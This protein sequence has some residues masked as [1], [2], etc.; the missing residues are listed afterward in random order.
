MWADADTWAKHE[1]EHVA[2]GHR[3]RSKRLLGVA[4]ALARAPSASLPRAMGDWAGAKAAYRLMAH[5]AVT[6]AA[7]LGAH[8]ARTAERAQAHARV[9]V[10]HD[11]TSVDFTGRGARDGLGPIHEAYSRGL[12]VHTSLAIL[13]D[14]TPLGVL[15]Q[16][17]WARPLHREGPPSR[18]QAR[19]VRRK[20]EGRESKRWAAGVEAAHA[21]AVAAAGAADAPRP[22]W[23]HVAD[24]EGDLYPFLATCQRLG[25]GFV[26]RA[27][28]NRRL[29]DDGPLPRYV[30]DEAR[31]AP[32]ALRFVLQVPAGPGRAARS[33][34]MLVRRARVVLA[35]PFGSPP[36]L[37]PIRAHVLLVQEA[38]PPPSGEP[39]CWYLLTN[40]P[41]D[42]PEALRTVVRAY[43]ARWIIEEFHM[44]LKTGCNFEGRR[45]GA[46]DRLEPLLAVCSAVAC[47]LLALRAEARAPSPAPA[48]DVLPAPVLAAVRA[49][50]PSL[51][52][53]ADARQVLRAIASLGGFLGRKGDGEPGWRTLWAGMNEVLA[54]ARGYEVGLA[55]AASKGL[56][57]ELG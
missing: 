56:A 28:Q 17:V 54:M 12:L 8:A 44:G 32:V 41:V 48:A 40:E 18:Q 55:S 15:A 20:A 29:A 24:R 9:L 27:A 14:G 10:V 3:A 43:E 38:L 31:G 49:R 53:D 19:H 22:R 11:T 5:P 34:P 2:L 13:P 1:F 6:H 36:G 33:V 57:N 23:V 25:D 51:P 47:R 39:L 52:A 35:P 21:V 30:L 4:A 7:V 26:V 46:R 42:T 50:R 37:E 16:H 45:L